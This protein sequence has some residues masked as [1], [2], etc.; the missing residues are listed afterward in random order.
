MEFIYEKCICAD[1]ECAPQPSVDAIIYRIPSTRGTVRGEGRRR[2]G[3]QRERG[4]ERKREREKGDHGMTYIW[5]T[6]RRVELLIQFALKHSLRFI[7]FP[8][9][10]PFRDYL[11]SPLATPPSTPFV[12]VEFIYREALFRQCCALPLSRP[13]KRTLI[14]EN[15]SRKVDG[16]KQ[17]GEDGAILLKTNSRCCGRN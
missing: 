10:P 14:R 4:G 5:P 2:E 13:A 8:T 7:S 9:L 11:S 3:E 1:N 12:F 6:G 17:S 16:I 15:Y